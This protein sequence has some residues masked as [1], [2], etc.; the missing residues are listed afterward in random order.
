MTKRRII[1]AVYTLLGIFLYL[2]SFYDPFNIKASSFFS[3]F[4]LG[5]CVNS[6]FFCQFPFHTIG[7]IAY[8]FGCAF[9]GI[10]F[11]LLGMKYVL[12]PKI[13]N[14]DKI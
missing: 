6:L 14:N 13:V 2:V 8:I 4:D 12:Y 5:F 10:I 1:G 7:N 3:S 9:F 11:V